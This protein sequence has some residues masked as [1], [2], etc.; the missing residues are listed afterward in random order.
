[1]N[2]RQ[3]IGIPNTANG[4]IPFQAGFRPL[5]FMTSMFVIYVSQFHKRDA[6]LLIL[7]VNIADIVLYCLYYDVYV[8][9]PHYHYS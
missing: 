6:Y 9:T 8:Y 7:T 4:V 2:E 5:Y 3:H 1:M